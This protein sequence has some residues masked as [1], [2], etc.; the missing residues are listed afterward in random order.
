MGSDG[1]WKSFPFTQVLVL[2]ITRKS[3]QI[4]RMGFDY[5]RVVLLEKNGSGLLS[6]PIRPWSLQS[7][8][9]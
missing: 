2:V 7:G 6:L 3:F 8:H 5:L 9:D 4:E 1:Y